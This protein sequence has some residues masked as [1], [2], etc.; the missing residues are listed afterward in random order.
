MSN[1]AT[2]SRKASFPHSL[3]LIACLIL[4]ASLLSYILPAGVYE[5][6]AT[7]GIFDPATFHYITNT[8]V[9]PLAALLSFQQGIVRS[10]TIISLLLVIGGATAVILSVGAIESLINYAIKRLAHRSIKILVPGI[11]VVMSLLGALAGNDSMMAFVAVGVAIAGRLKLDRIV[12]VALFYLSYITGQAAGPTTAIALV[13]QTLAGVPPVSGAGARVIVW[14]LLTAANAIYTTR[15]AL[16]ISRDPSRSIMGNVEH[17]NTSEEDSAVIQNARFEFRAIASVVLL[18]GCFI[19]YA[20]GSKQWKWSF[21][22]LVTCVLV[23]SAFIAALYRLSPNKFASTLCAGARD[24]GGVCL[25]LGAAQVVGMTLTNGNIIHTIAHTV[26]GL[27]HGLDAGIAAIG[28]FIF[29]LLFNLMVPSGTTQAAIV[30]PVT[31]PMAD[32]MGITRQVLALATQMGDGLTNCITP[33]SSVMI[34]SIA[35]GGVA[36][37]KWLRYVLPLVFINILIAMGALYLLQMMQWM[38]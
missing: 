2:E 1:T 38:G 20:I 12:A 25:I 34:G 32:V 10:A 23:T 31:V 19:L 14:A 36:Y 29:N 13:M 37:N 11:C 26:A 35:I 24:M 9:S 22:Y 16:R 30:L 21:E 4:V 3:I 6:N 7:T 8:P 18:F 17:S 27:L 15:Y 28:L 5:K 33:I